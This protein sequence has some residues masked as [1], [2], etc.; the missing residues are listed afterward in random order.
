[1]AY[2]GLV[3][4]AMA[5]D[6]LSHYMHLWGSL[7]ASAVIHKKLM[8]ALLGTTLQWLDYTPTGRI[9]SRCTADIGAS[10]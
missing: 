8:D 10:K 4:L 7:R 9:I 2:A 1:M 6:V 5:T 3:L